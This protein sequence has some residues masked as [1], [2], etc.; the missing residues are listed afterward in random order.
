MQRRRLYGCLGAIVVAAMML[1]GCNAP[2]KDAEAP[3]GPPVIAYADG[4]ADITMLGDQSSR[5]K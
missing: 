5:L 3:E 4:Y 1:G 2:A